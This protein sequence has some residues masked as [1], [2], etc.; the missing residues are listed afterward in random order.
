MRTLLESMERGIEGL[1]DKQRDKDIGS[2]RSELVDT[3]GRIEAGV[4]YLESH[5]AKE[6]KKSDPKYPAWEEIAL[7]YLNRYHELVERERELEAKISPQNSESDISNNYHEL[8]GA[9]FWHA[10]YFGHIRNSKR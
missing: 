3:Q 6:P 5:F 9:E 8:Q 1:E 4:G 2:L 10:F 7:K